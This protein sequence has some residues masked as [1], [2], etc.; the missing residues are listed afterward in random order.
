M[1]NYMNTDTTETI[2]TEQAAKHDMHWTEVLELAEK[3]GFIRQAYG[4]TAILITHKNI[5][6]TENN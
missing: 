1:S 6:E 3:H 5:A 4:G 2:T